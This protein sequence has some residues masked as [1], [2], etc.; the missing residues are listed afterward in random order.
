MKIQ[1][2]QR[3]VGQAPNRNKVVVASNPVRQREMIDPDGNQIDPRTKRI[4]KLNTER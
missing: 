3:T 4:I 2:K 1:T